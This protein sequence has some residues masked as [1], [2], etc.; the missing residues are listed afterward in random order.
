MSNCVSN[1]S[2]YMPVQAAEA[3]SS[4]TTDHS[5]SLSL[6][7]P[8]DLPK[9]A[10]PSQILR[11]QHKKNQGKTAKKC[12]IIK[13]TIRKPSRN[14]PKQESLLDASISTSTSNTTPK[15]CHPSFEEY[16]PGV[17]D[18]QLIT[19]ESLCESP[20]SDINMAYLDGTLQKAKF[21]EVKKLKSLLMSL[22]SHFPIGKI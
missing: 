22:K 17:D 11:N 3:L 18:V 13:K 7:S 5:P 8:D 10:K 9:N 6:D 4:L 1:L 15:V 14:L 2:L 20:Q 19:P 21:D 16:I 12:P